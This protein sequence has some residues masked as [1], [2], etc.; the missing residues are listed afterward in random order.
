MLIQRLPKKAAGNE[1]PACACRAPVAHVQP[2]GDRDAP[3]LAGQI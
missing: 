2:V 1:P 3:A